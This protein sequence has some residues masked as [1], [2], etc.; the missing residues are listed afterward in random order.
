MGKQAGAWSAVAGFL[1]FACG[2]KFI[3]VDP[4]AGG[5]SGMTSAGKSS[6]GT[7]VSAGTDGG[8]SGGRGG[9]KPTGGAGKGGTPSA[10]GSGP[11]TGGVAGVGGIGGIGGIGVAGIG[12]VTTVPPIPTN[13]LELWLRAD[14]GVELDA[15]GVS[16]WKDASGKH[17]D[18]AQLQ[19][20]FRPILVANAIAGKPGLV[21]DGADD[22]LKLPSLTTSF[23]GG[24]SIFV[25][26]QEASLNECE[27]Y[28][29]AANGQEIDDIHFGDWQKSLIFEVEENWAHDT[30]YPVPLNE[31]ALAV[32]VQNTTGLTL[33]RSNSLAA[34]EGQVNL[35]PVAERAGVYIGK[36]L[37][38]GCV[39]F[40][41]AI[42]EMILYSRG[43][44]DAEVL[45]IEGYLQ[46]KW[47]CCE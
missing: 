26:L 45:K 27:A 2:D 18:A 33:L 47:G 38:A 25:M 16:T 34:G 44:S 46:K 17:R 30:N 5:S 11:S 41:G 1:L 6:G 28:F 24:V 42:G 22:Y 31:P 12:G 37:Y 10:G 29:E 7:D 4:G 3:A 39:P 13:G 36:T 21:F 20:E 32:A 40:D 19:P 9:S 43:V 15:D 8:G 14:D 23:A 35:A